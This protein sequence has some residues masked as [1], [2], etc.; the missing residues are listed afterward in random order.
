MRLDYYD[1]APD[2]LQTYRDKIAAVTVADVQR[3]ARAYLN[4][5]RQ[6]LVLV[7][8]PAEFAAPPES[9]GLPVRKVERKKP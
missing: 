4:P 8:N 3:V 6:Q 2:Y 9:L 5:D 7:G 1:Y